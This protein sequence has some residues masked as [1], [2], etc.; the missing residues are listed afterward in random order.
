MEITIRKALAEFRKELVNLLGD[1]LLEV[2]L[3]GSRAR[4]DAEPDSDVDVMLLVRER[5]ENLR[6]RVMDVSA[7]LSLKYELV[8][9]TLI[10][11]PEELADEEDMETLLYS[12][13][14]KEGIVI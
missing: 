8:I 6:D 12:S 3:F 14:M 11:T 4:G 1:N 13:L 7:P 9:M 10:M 5:T 2:R